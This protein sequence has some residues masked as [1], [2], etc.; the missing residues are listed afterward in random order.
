MNI[1]GTTLCR[2]YVDAILT[3][4]PFGLRE[5]VFG[6]DIFSKKKLSQCYIED[7]APEELAKRVLEMM[8]PVIKFGR[9][10]LGIKKRL[11]YL[12]PVFDTQEGIGLWQDVSKRF[13]VNG[14]VLGFE[15]C[16]S[17]S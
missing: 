15:S 1:A 16:Q 13:E 4:P 5:N 3:D 11:V 14:E 10:S 9:H 7:H 6:Q 17:C 8:A 12:F 2:R